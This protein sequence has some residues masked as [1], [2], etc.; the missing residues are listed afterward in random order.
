MVA[1]GSTEFQ[2]QTTIRNA[3]GE[4]GDNKRRLEQLSFHFQDLQN[5]L[6]DLARSIGSVK[7]GSMTSK[8]LMSVFVANLAKQMSSWTHFL[9]DANELG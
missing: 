4:L 3:I 2:I 1:G 9:S 7:N 6:E 8:Y 5:Q